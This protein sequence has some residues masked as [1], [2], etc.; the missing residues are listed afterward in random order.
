MRKDIS[1][2]EISHSEDRGVN[3]KVWVNDPDEEKEALYKET[4]IKDNSESTYADFGESIVSD[5]CALLKIPC[6]KIELV[7]KDG[8][9]GCISYNFCNRDTFEELIEMACVIQNTRLRFQ[10]K[11]MYDPEKK[12]SYGVEM[13]LEGLESISTS[14][15][16]FAELRKA[17]LSDVLTD[18]L[19]DHYDRNPANLSVIR[20]LEGVRLSPKYDNGTSLSISVPEEVLREFVS[21]YSEQ[22]TLHEKV[23]ENVLSKIGYLG[24]KFVKYPDLET[25]IFNYYYD[26][27]KDF[28][29][30]V[31]EKLTDENIDAILS[32][33][34]YDELDCIHK[35]IIRGKLKTNRD[36]MLNR[37]KVISKK[38]TLDKIVYN[39]AASNNFVSHV[40]KGTIQDIIPEY[41]SC[42][43]IKDEDSDYDLTLDAQI[44]EKI[45]TVVDIT[46]LARYFEIP[47]ED[48]TK[49]EKS[50]LKWNII[51]E[52]IQKASKDEKTFETITSRLGFLPEDKNLLHSLI[53]D[54][55]KNENDIFE[56][57]EI[58]YGEKGIGE[59]NLNLYIAK[60]FI[61]A[62]TMKK[63]IRDQRMEE[64]RTFAQTAKEVVELEHIVEE[65]PVRV[66]NLQ[67]VGITDK[68]QILAIQYEV[69][70]AHRDNP[71]LTHNQMFKLGN[72]L[73]AKELKDI[74]EEI[75]PGI[76]IDKKVAD[77]IRKHTIELEDGK[78][79]VLFDK[80]TK[81]SDIALKMGADYYGQIAEHHSGEGVTLSLITKKGGA[82][83]EK[84]SN[85]AKEVIDKYSTPDLPKK[86]FVLKESE[87]KN[88]VSCFIVTS[89]DGSDAKIPNITVP[90][91]YEKMKKLF[92]E[93][94]KDK[95]HFEE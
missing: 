12:E 41:N 58:I 27:V 13:I 11:S 81:H 74:K 52:N 56:A 55:F 95:S 22:E 49:R 34:K 53:K 69:A 78:K 38:N 67:K 7:E 70:K 24:R 10:S 91:M 60:K 32:Q 63:D 43:G 16:N 2:W 31:Q 50:L 17:F 23:R 1:T 85:Y 54:K 14:K 64:L 80:F 46:Q 75:L 15:T 39:K 3:K 83:P 62:T 61:D 51:M 36:S 88:A 48:L 20:S 19:I 84:V 76:Y 30:V 89:I 92:N 57:R 21:E 5:I 6:A 73:A 66:R 90:K 45:Q 44:P 87:G 79:L 93:K 82:F 71:R 42:I 28:I 40:Q 33:E 68:K 29:T 72:D 8:K 9:R 26:D 77:E 47:L 4:Q 25:F 94:E 86:A 59:E 35:E 65:I 37:F 18:S